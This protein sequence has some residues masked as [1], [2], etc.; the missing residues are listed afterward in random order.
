MS[1]VPNGRALAKCMMITENNR[2]TLNQRICC[3]RDYSLHPVFF[4]HTLNRHEYFLSFNDGD[5]QTNLR[6]DDLLS[7]PI[8]LPPME[9]QEQF[10]A[11]VEQTGK[12]KLA[13]QQSLDK[14]ELLKKSLMQEYFG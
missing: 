10:A 3:L 14:L 1:D 12:S 5:S 2:Y 8:I 4:M 11:F 9:L 7:C 6:K 13:I